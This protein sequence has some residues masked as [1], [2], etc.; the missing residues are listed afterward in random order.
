M[1][2]G[3]CGAGSC[4]PTAV[5]TPEQFLPVSGTMPFDQSVGQGV[6]IWGRRSMRNR[7]A[8]RSSSSATRRAP[9]SH[10]S[11]RATSPRRARRCRLS[12]VLIG[13]PNR[14]NGG[15]LQRFEG[16]EIPILGVTFDGATPTTGDISR[17]IARQYDGW[18]DFPTYPLN[19]FATAN[20][21]RDCVSARRLSECRAR[22]CAVPGV[23]RRHGLLHDPEP[24]AAAADPP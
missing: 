17:D 5:G 16:V 23:V 9:G 18:A 7:Q 21:C 11:K 15:I 10:R 19:P 1:L 20:R 24:A 13:N 12:F 22:R 2:T 8:I 6:P 14:P 3:F 4:T